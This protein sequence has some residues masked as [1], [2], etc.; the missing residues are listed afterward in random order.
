MKYNSQKYKLVRWRNYTCR[1]LAHFTGDGEIES[2][3]DTMRVT[4]ITLSLFSF[5]VLAVFRNLMKTGLVVPM[6]PLIFENYDD[7]IK[8]NVKP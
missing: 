8:Y 2:N 1:I 6:P 5:L 4:Y 3:D 7:L